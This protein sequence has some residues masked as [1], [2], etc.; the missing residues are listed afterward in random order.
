MRFERLKS[1]QVGFGYTD[2]FLFRFGGGAR[3][4]LYVILVIAVVTVC[5]IVVQGLSLLSRQPSLL[6]PDC[7]KVT[8]TR[9]RGGRQQAAPRAHARKC[10]VIQGEAV[11]W[12][13]ADLH[14]FARWA[15]C[16]PKRD[17][18]RIQTE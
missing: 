7:G 5:L 6:G 18:Y 10:R 3:F 12:T 17:H 14:V 13:T 4:T 9:E 1:C 8:V 16:R 11:V 2:A 15:I